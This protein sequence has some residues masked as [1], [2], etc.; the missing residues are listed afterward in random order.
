MISASVIKEL[1]NLGYNNNLTQNQNVFQ[2]TARNL[3]GISSV[4]ITFSNESIPEGCRRKNR[5]LLF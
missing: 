4:N 1:R 2:I 5:I 3:L